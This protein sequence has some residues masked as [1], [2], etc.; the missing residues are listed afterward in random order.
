LR[1]SALALAANGAWRRGGVW[2]RW[3]QRYRGSATGIAAGRA[4]DASSA[5]NNDCA[6]LWDKIGIIAH[7]ASERSIGCSYR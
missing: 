7:Q 2:R 1:A 6:Y 3:R 4:S 5:A